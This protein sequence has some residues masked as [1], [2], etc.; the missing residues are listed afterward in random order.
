MSI[1]NYL[2]FRKKQATHFLR[3][4]EIPIEYSVSLP[5]PT[6]RFYISAYASFANLTTTI[7]GKQVEIQPPDRWW[8]FDA[9]TGQILVYA[10]E[11]VLPFSKENFNAVLLPSIQRSLEEQEDLLVR[12]EQGINDVCEAFFEN[13]NTNDEKRKI[14]QENLTHYLPENI[15]PRYKALC[16]DFFEWLNSWPKS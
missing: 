2:E 6:R 8:A 16:P 12:V 7:L 11:T 5:I 15:L 1:I 10:R 3:R 4:Y 9:T 13:K 14:L